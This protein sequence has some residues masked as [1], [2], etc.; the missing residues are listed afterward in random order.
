[1]LVLPAAMLEPVKPEP[2]TKVPK[3]TSD[4]TA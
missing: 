1:M 3:M 4:A 2:A